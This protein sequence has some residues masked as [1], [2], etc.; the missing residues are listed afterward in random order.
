MA[1]SA[2]VTALILERPTCLE[3]ISQETGITVSEVGAVLERIT[4]VLELQ[5]EAARC[6]ACELIT[7]VFSVGRPEA[8]RPPR[9][10]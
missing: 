6:R 7:H 9:R 3:C 4:T 10:G 2:L 1:Q 5:A 8:P